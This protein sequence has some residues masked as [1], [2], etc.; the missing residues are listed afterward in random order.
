MIANCVSDTLNPRDN[1]GIAHARARPPN[2]EATTR[3]PEA[4]P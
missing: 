1:G 3:C 4:P 2:P